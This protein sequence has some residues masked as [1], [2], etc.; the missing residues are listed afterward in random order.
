[1]L[2]T[3]HPLRMSTKDHVEYLENCRVVVHCAND[4][5]GH[6]LV[7]A[8]FG[9]NPAETALFAPEANSQEH[10]IVSAKWKEPFPF[11]FRNSSLRGL[12]LDM[13]NAIPI[14]V[15]AVL[16]PDM[17][18]DM[19]RLGERLPGRPSFSAGWSGGEAVVGM[20]RASGEGVMS[21]AAVTGCAS[22]W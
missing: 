15:G 19:Q 10:S 4:G 21:R 1:M 22:Y 8:T 14:K 13:E 11:E 6:E 20:A 2:M 16:N 5:K 18:R 9:I 17:C 3:L 12:F 7:I